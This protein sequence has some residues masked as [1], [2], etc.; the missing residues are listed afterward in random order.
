MLM[1]LIL[2]FANSFTNSIS[3]KGSKK[4]ICIE[5]FLRKETSSFS[6]LFIL[7]VTSYED[8][9]EFLSLLMEA[10]E[11]VYKSSET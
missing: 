1:A 3:L 5:F 8:K 6:G 9:E 10:P 4:L 2:E 11:E 7:Q